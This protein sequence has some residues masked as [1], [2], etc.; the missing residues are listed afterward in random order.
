ML[1]GFADEWLGFLPP[2]SLEA[3]RRDLDLS[4]AQAGTILALPSLAGLVGHGLAVAADFVDRRVLGTLGA[5]GYAACLITFAL[6]HSFAVLALAALLLG[7]SAD[8]LVHGCEVALV[9]LY[10]DDP[11]PVLARANAAASVGDLLGPLTL[12]AAA[13]VGIGW[14]TL[15]AA[16]GAL[17]LLYAAWLATGRFPAPQRPEHASTPVAAVL[18]VLRDRRVVALAIIAGLFGMLDEPFLG[19]V[20]AYLQNVRRLTPAVATGIA[21]VMVAG[22]VAGFLAVPAFTRRLTPRTILATSAATVCVTVASIIVA[23][24]PS[25]QA[26]A[27]FTFGFAGAVF[28]SVL[29]A[30]TLRL[31]PGLAGTTAAVVST[32][33]LFGAGFPLLVGAVSDRFGL[34]AG[35]S[36]YVGVCALMLGLVLMRFRDTSERAGRSGPRASRPA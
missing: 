3:I 35:L 16:G 33:G 8:A 26:A 20:L 32:V 29:Q 22:G 19:F 12:A 7:V 25:V 27:G 2:G 21:A 15:F 31:T 18:S 9:D 5:L 34:T 1:A 36:M 30:A 23:P 28:W 6:G 10:R 14:R 17:M 24:A 13:A 11:A 4:Y